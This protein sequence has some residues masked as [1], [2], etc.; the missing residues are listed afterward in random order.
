MQYELTITLRL[1]SDSSQDRV[2]KQLTSLF[3]FGT[4]KESIVDGLQLLEDPRFV[5]LSVRRKGK[6]AR[7]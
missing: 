6:R 2:T 3:D 1:E 7:Q 4:V 5:G